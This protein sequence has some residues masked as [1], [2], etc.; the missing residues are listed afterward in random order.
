M[1]FDAMRYH[2][3]SEKM[4]Y[5]YTGSTYFIINAMDWLAKKYGDIHLEYHEETGWR[6]STCYVHNSWSDD[7]WVSGDGS[8]RSALCLAIEL[9]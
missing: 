8:V 4:G 9:S 3:A 7:G 1:E 6:V 2:K 5:L